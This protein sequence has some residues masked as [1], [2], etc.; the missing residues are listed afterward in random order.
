[1]NVAALLPV[2]RPVPSRTAVALACLGYLLLVITV[3]L[4]YVGHF[5]APLPFWDQWDAEGDTLLR[6]W[7]EGTLRLPDLWAPH[8]EHRLLPSRLISL[9][10]YETTGAWD[11]LDAARLNVLL[12]A[13]PGVALLALLLRDGALHGWRWLLLPVMLAGQL[14][15][16]GWEN[17]LVGFQS[18][19]YVM[20]SLVLATVALAAWRPDHPYAI[21]AMLALSV[22]SCLTMASGL[23]APVATLAVLLA[24][25][26]IEGRQPL[27]RTIACVLL[28]S[29]ALIAYGTTPP[30]PGHAPL[31]APDLTTLVD[32]TV[33]LLGWPVSMAHWAWVP[34]W[35]PG[36]IAC[37]WLWFRRDFERADLMMAGLML[38]AGLQAGASAYG[39]GNGLVEPPSRYMDL[40]STGLMANAWFAMRLLEMPR[41]GA[42]RAAGALVAIA[43]VATFTGGHAQRLERDYAAMKARHALSM[44][45]MRNVIAYVDGGNPVVLEQPPLH[46][47]YPDAR[48]LRGWLDDP[49]LLQALRGGDALSAPVAAAA[50]AAV[51]T[52]PTPTPAPAH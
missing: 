46:I 4:W 9:A 24:Q 49:V 31:R 42:A 6:P 3:R 27:R 40:L 23:L 44:V 34:L 33:H 25:S 30:M 35:A 39:R 20:Q 52:T 37:A 2:N 36:V 47:P 21:A 48:A 51:P 12:A 17:M 43:F 11:N 28:L 8:N 50:P 41:P 22:V 15:P 19:F 7:I 16:F 38:W 26:R 32:A 13:L 1:M 29:I 18:Q 45:Q 5:A 14:L 10:L